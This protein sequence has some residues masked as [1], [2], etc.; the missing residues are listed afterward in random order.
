MG[1][2]PT[3]ADE[4]RRLYEEAE[5]R[6]AKAMEQLVQRD[7][8]GEVLARVAENTLAVAKLGMDAADLVVRNLRIAGRRDVVELARQLAR[9]E[10]KLERMLQE[11]ERLQDALAASAAG[12]GRAP[13]R[14]SSARSRS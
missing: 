4:A 12:D 2:R 6:T 13:A 10:D 14:R 3:P 8:F 9:T 1:E 5:S 11:I 7:S